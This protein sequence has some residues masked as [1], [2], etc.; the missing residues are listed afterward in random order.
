MAITKLASEIL[1]GAETKAGVFN[2]DFL[3]SLTLTNALNDAYRNAYQSIAMSDSDFYVKEY[4]LTEDDMSEDKDGW[5]DLPKGIYIIK[6]VTIGEVEI[7]RCPPKEKIAGTYIIQNSRFKFYGNY[8]RKPIVIHYIPDPQTVTIPAPSIEIAL[9]ASEIKDY[10]RVTDKGFYYKTNTGQFFYDFEAQTSEP[11]DVYKTKN[12]K[13]HEGTLQWDSESILVV[14][15]DGEILE[16]LTEDFQVGPENPIVDIAVDD[17]YM[18]VS[19]KDGTIILVTEDNQTIWNIKAH[20]GH[21]TLGAIHGMKTDD[22]TLYGCL[23]EDEDN[24]LHLSSFVPDTIMNYPTNA[25]FEMLEVDL[26]CLLMSMNGV[27]N[28]YISETLKEETIKNFR[29]QLRQNRAM[30]VRVTNLRRQNIVRSL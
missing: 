6:S 8:N 24:V 20:T 28:A 22:S 30:P 17:P 2:V 15:S 29:D 10:G 13:Y 18:M 1:N 26:A 3:T 19:Y 12:M 5:Y 11:V 27:T 16:D 21:K 25:L 7:Q 9:D 4:T 14:D 23:Y